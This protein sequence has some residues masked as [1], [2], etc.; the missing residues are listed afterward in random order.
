MPEE[1]TSAGT[2]DI[3]YLKSNEFREIACDGVMGGP[4][5]RGSLWLAFF[6]ERFPL[7]RI[8]RHHLQPAA[9]PGEVFIDKDVPGQPVEGRHGLVRNIE[10][11]VYM[12]IETATQLHEWLGQQIDAMKG[13]GKT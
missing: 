7:P 6:T 8:M 4:T 9:S 10:F 11:G 2:I 3:N 1:P 13:G 12:N 5:P